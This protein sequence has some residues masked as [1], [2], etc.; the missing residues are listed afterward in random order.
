MANP[1]VFIA[2]PSRDMWAP[3]FGMSLVYLVG[4]TPKFAAADGLPNVAITIS[5]H[6]ASLVHANRQALAEQFM[7]S[8][9]THLLFLDDDMEFPAWTL[10]S[11]LKRDVGIVG[12]NYV[13]RTYP[14]VPVAVGMD[15]KR[16]YHRDDSKGSVEVQATGTGVMLIH[17]EVLEAMPRPWFDTKYIEQAREFQGEDYYFC[18]KAREHGFSVHID[19]DVSRCIVHHGAAGYDWKLCEH[20]APAAT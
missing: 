8:Q 18:T 15:G 2:I 5:N 9:C 7:K 19:C 3:E 13:K 14:T 11:M 20:D 1:N 4:Q 16:I 12:V 10:S 17:R 6:A